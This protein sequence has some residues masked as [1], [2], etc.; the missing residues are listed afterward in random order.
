MD[1]KAMVTVRV[2]ARSTWTVVRGWASNQRGERMLVT[3]L[4]VGWTIAV[5]RVTGAWEFLHG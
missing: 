2:L 1:Q 3:V 4:K 5:A